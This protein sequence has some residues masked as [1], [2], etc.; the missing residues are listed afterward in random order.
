MWQ[1]FCSIYLCNDFA[2]MVHIYGLWEDTVSGMNSFCSKSLFSVYCINVIW[3]SSIIDLTFICFYMCVC[4]HIYLCGFSSFVALLLFT[5]SRYGCEHA[6][7]V[8][9]LGPFLMSWILSIML[10]TLTSL[11]LTRFLWSFTSQ[12]EAV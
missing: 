2:D 1:V 8:T 3:R 4:V 9:Y 6:I 12:E 10:S 7:C 11:P 5:Y